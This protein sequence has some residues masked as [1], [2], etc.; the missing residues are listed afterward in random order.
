MAGFERHLRLHVTFVGD[1]GSDVNDQADVAILDVINSPCSARGPGGCGKGRVYGSDADGDVASHDDLVVF[2]VQRV[3]LRV[4][5]Q[6]RFALRLQ[7]AE[8]RRR[9][10][11]ERAG[12]AA[13][14]EDAAGDGGDTVAAQPAQIGQ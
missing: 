3:N 12:A 5:Q 10:A 2:A 11:D 9:H 4:R 14:A 7:Q 6:L 13:E 1:R 8:A